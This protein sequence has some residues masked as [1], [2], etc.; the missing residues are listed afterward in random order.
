M[1]SVL[2]GYSAGAVDYM[3]KPL[4]AGNNKIQS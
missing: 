2:E 1:D 3:I 4:R